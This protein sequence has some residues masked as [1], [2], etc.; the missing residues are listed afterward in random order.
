[1]KMKVILQE[2]Q[3]LLRQFNLVAFV[4]NDDWIVIRRKDY[5]DL[6]IN[7]EPFNSVVVLFHV[8]SEVSPFGNSS[9]HFFFVK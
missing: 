2:I 3:P 1:M 6:Y 4:A 8:E 9:C 7:S 5:V